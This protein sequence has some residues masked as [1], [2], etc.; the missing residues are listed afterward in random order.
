M[1]WDEIEAAVRE[2]AADIGAAREG[3]KALNRIG[4]RMR[5]DDDFAPDVD[6]ATVNA[7]RDAARM[8]CARAKLA[9]KLLN[10][11]AHRVDRVEQ[12]RKW[13]A[14]SFA[15]AGE[16]LDV[17]REEMAR[18]VAGDLQPERVEY[19]P[20][21]RADVAPADKLDA[22]RALFDKPSHPSA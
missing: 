10:R 9:R 21:D 4:R 20:D 8:R 6:I 1:D 19:R 15:M 12:A 22:L 17:C 14:E 5:D 7:G 3:L 11:Y 16:S 13:D 2:A 18:F